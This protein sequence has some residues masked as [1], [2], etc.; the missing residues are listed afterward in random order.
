[1]RAVRS[2][3]VRT[4][5]SGTT[6]VRC[7]LSGACCPKQSRS[8]WAAAPT[9]QHQLI[10]YNTDSAHCKSDPQPPGVPPENV[11][12]QCPDLERSV[13]ACPSSTPHSDKWK[14]RNGRKNLL[15]VIKCASLI[16]QWPSISSYKR[17]GE[18]IGESNTHT[19]QHQ[20]HRNITNCSFYSFGPSCCPSFCPAI[21]SEIKPLLWQGLRGNLGTALKNASK[22]QETEK[23]YCPM[24]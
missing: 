5:L 11:R 1:M 23:R 7:V 24:R 2:R 19:P 16:G 20:E 15:R 18:N 12:F 21:H 9:G 17:T 4:T 8:C 6:T 13:H 14:K 22:F 10:R 3:T